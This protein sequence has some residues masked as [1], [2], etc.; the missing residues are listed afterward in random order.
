MITVNLMADLPLWSQ[1][2]PCLDEG[3]QTQGS[4]L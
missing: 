3:H 2:Y 1:A 4:D